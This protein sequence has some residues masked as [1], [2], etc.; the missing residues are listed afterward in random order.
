MKKTSILMPIMFCRNA[1]VSFCSSKF[2]TS[3]HQPSL[4][5]LVLQKHRTSL[6]FGAFAQ[7]AL[8]FID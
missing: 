3:N 8:C 2:A 5:C 6:K 1:A 7:T 4:I